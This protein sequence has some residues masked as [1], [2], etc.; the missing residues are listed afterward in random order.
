MN[1]PHADR[2]TSPTA[3]PTATTDADI[4][5]RL[6][7]GVV[8][9]EPKSYPGAM[10]SP[11]PAKPGPSTRVPVR[12]GSAP[13]FL[14]SGVIAGLVAALVVALT[15]SEALVLLGIPDPGPV[16]TYGLP[17]VRAIAEVAAVIAIGSLLLAAF[18]VPPQK[19]GV[20]DVDG[21]RAMRTA[22]T[23]AAVWAACSLVLV[24]LTLSDTSGQPFSTAVQPS[25]MFPAIAQVEMADAWRWTA[26]IAVVIAIWS[27]VVLR[28]WWAPIILGAALLG[29]MPLAFS[30]HSSAGGNHDV[31]TNSLVLH[32][33][34]ASLWAGGLFALLAHARRKGAYTDVAARRFSA[35]ATVCFVVVAISGVINS[36]VRVSLSDLLSTT[37]GRLI[38]AKIVALILLGVFGWLQRRRA[39]P[40]LAADPHS[41]RT[42]IRFAGGEIIIFAATF[43]LAVGLGRT[44]PPPPSAVPT[45]TEVELGYNLSGPPTFLRLA[46]EWRFDLI[47]GTAALVLAVVYIVGVLTLRR[48]GDSWPTGRI[49]A[50]LCGCAVL[51]IATSS[52]VGRYAPAVFSVH[53]G[54]HMALSMLGPVLLVLGAPVTLA[55]RA[56]RPAGKDA[57]DRKSVV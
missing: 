22:S 1:L 37:Y 54:A 55:L 50:W 12:T 34:G 6:R 8:V 27:R 5:A 41:P 3:T 11:D 26:I 53:M 4:D 32:L 57:P 9:G 48:R 56:I 39:L 51:L 47:F 14:I 2:A 30:G 28:W 45:V 21:Y 18:F 16:T 24:P 40:D 25:K 35:V 15:A 20:L 17:A 33:V 29:L 44:P 49:I 46:T 42:L 52:G 36:L 23:A 7:R 10:P 31:A 38:V 13:I 43:G 19:S